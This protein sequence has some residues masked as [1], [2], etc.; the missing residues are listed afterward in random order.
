MH[1]VRTNPE[2]RQ[3]R[4]METENTEP[5]GNIFTKKRH[6]HTDDKCGRSCGSAPPPG[7]AI[8][9][10]SISLPKHS[11]V[12]AP[13]EREFRIKRTISRETRRCWMI[14]WLEHFRPLSSEEADAEPLTREMQEQKWKINESVWNRQP[15]Q[16]RASG[17]PVN[18]RWSYYPQT[19]GKLLR[20][21]AA[22]EWSAIPAPQS[23]R[24]IKTGMVQKRHRRNNLFNTGWR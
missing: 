21:T 4:R 1:H 13:R 11:N 10:N 12:P 3:W 17:T 19:E 16:S 15:N 14:G 23:G 9:K 5:N 6:T 18:H 24:S 7:L 22:Q 20:V 8:V 2:R